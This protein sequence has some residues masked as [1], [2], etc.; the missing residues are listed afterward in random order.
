M[1]TINK[2]ANQISTQKMLFT[3]SHQIMSQELNEI[4]SISPFNFS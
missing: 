2:D 4:E 3:V 1:P